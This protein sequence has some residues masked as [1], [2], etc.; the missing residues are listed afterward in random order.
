[1]ID[2][3]SSNKLPQPRAVHIDAAR[4]M[5][6][7]GILLVNIWSFV[8]GFG[9]LRYGVMPDPSWAD[10]AAVFMVAFIAEQKF[11]P[12]FAFLFGA[13]FALQTRALRR[14]MPDWTAVQARHRRR[15]AWLLG[16][17][18]A[19]G[20]LVWAGDIL[21]VYG[22]TGLL[23]VSL[24][25]AR[26]ARVC[27]ALRTWCAVWLLLLAINVASALHFGPDDAMAEQA[28]AFVE[29]TQAAHA[30]YTAGAFLETFAQ[31]VGDYLAVSAASLFLVPHLLVLFLIGILA[32]RRGWLTAPWRHARLWRRVRMTGLAIGLPVNLL[33]ASAATAEAINPL[34]PLPYGDLVFAL[35]PVGGS[36]L[37]AA[38]LAS[39][40]LARGAVR[41]WLARWLAPVG[42]MSLT[43]YLG[44]SLLGM[45]LLQGAGL[46][47]GAAA[48]RS[49]WLL[50]VIA[51]SIM[52]FQ[53][54]A[55]RWWLSA[56]ARGPVE[57]MFDR[58]PRPVQGMAP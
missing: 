56:H 22:L 57:S 51:V 17:G 7:F 44:Q 25:G 31:R 33:W 28:I 38:Y 14:R 4:G 34:A 54:L 11:Y 48:A 15:L 55:S 16:W 12:I 2:T 50:L 37:G 32:V 58:G 42:R 35:L 6:V 45:I 10:R 53:V 47:L 13:S 1:M 9:Y 40:M 23:I 3:A 52:L 26:L 43:N 27:A 18:V 8:W 24:A 29:E 46:G 41:D 5:A 19:H 39:V 21:T 30:I 20:V 36:L 49:P